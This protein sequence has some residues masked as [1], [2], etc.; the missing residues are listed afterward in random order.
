[1]FDVDAVSDEI[2]NT[3][4][5]SCLGAFAEAFVRAP[6][7]TRIRNAVHN[8]VVIVAF[9]VRPDSTPFLRT[10]SSLHTVA[11]TDNDFENDERW[12]PESPTLART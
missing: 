12:A 10:S 6:T 7:R 9:V 1:M 5:L 2:G 8:V 4:L 11:T 3:H